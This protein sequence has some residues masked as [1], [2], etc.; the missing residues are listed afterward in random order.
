MCT[1]GTRVSLLED[2]LAWATAS[3]SSCI[4]WLNG[5]AGTG[6]STIARTLC[7]RLESQSLIGASFFISRDQ[8]DRREASNIVRSIAYQLAVRWR[9]VSD[10][11]CAKLREMPVSAT[12]S[13][14]QQITDFIITPARELPR[15]TSFIIVI[16]ALDEAFSNFAGRPGGD[17]LLLL[18]QQLLQL[19]GRVR[20]FLTSRNESSIQQMFNTLSTNSQKVVKLHDLDNTIVRE[21]ITTYLKH[22]FTVIRETRLDPVLTG[23]PSNEVVHQIVQLS[24]LLFVYAATVLRFIDSRRHSPRDRLA[25]YL[26]QQRTNTRASPYA[27]LD[28]LYRQILSDAVRDS[29]G[30]EEFLCE[31]LRAVMAVIVLAETPLSLEALS[32]LSGVS[33]DDTGMAVDSLSS[34][35]VDG[36]SDVRVFHPSFPDF[37]CDASRIRDSRL[38][39][40]PNVGHGLIALRCLEL[41]NRHLRYDIC[42][43]QDPTVANN[44]L[45]DLDVRLRENVSDALRYAACFWC[46]HLTASDAPTG[47]IMNALNEFCQKHLFH[48]VEVL[49]LVKYVTPAE[50]ALLKAIEW[51]KVCSIVAQRE[52]G[53]P[54]TSACRN[55]LQT[56]HPVPYIS[57]RI[58]HEFCELTPF[59]SV[60]TRCTRIA[61]H[62]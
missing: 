43:I 50:A 35:L 18:G 21:D 17:L 59:P 52:Q 32:I 9:S 14:Q 1:P 24:G 26:G 31:R 62:S 46:N 29:D 48:W 34:L 40:V 54:H 27:Q 49:S 57:Y 23:W 16:D 7:E 42:K 22:S 60:P 41:M 33:R 30:D 28:G 37:V 38:C 45:Q 11:L 44:D 20:L 58:S 8:S 5:L 25:Q 47:L 10:A 3:D 6:K 56:P 15:D 19:A 36:T 13:L 12:R 53:E 51:C 39:V 2:L 61:V 55:A 4:F